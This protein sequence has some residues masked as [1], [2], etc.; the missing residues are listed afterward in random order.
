MSAYIMDTSSTMRTRRFCKAARFSSRDL[1]LRGMYCLANGKLKVECRVL[2]SILAEA[3]PVI[4]ARRTYGWSTESPSCCRS[5]VHRDASTLMTVDLPAPAPPWTISNGGLGNSFSRHLAFTR[6][7]QNLTP[8][9]TTSFWY[10]SKPWIQVFSSSSEGSSTVRKMDPF[11]LLL[12]SA[13]SLNR[14]FSEKSS[15]GKQNW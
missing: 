12:S 9:L 7:L 5:L 11:S 1:S 3:H 4:E 8:M 10:M 6:S 15:S 13:L 14:S 2:P